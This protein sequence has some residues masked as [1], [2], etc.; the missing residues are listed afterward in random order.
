METYNGHVRTP[1]DAIILFEACRIGL[2][3]R[4]QRRLSEKERQAVKSGSVFVWDEREAGMRRWTDGKSWSASRVSGSFLTY[5]EMEGKRGGG[6][7]TQASRAGK[8]PDSNRGS[9]EDPGEGGE[10]GPDGYRYKP[11]GLMKQSFSI[12]TST[13]QHLHLISYYARSHPTAPGLNQPSTDPALR[14]I[15]PQ[16][17]LYPE[18]SVND[19]QNL[20][21]VTRGPM[22]RPGFSI[23]PHSLPYARPG[24]AHAQP[25]ATA[26]YN[27]HPPPITSAPH[28]AVMPYPAYLPPLGA[29][30][31]HSSI[32]YGHHPHHPQLPAPYERSVH[33]ADSTLPP[34]MQQH[35]PNAASGQ[36]VPFYT[37]ARSPRSHPPII[38]GAPRMGSPGHPHGSPHSHAQANGT[39][40]KHAP[41]PAP[42]KNI[43]LHDNGSQDN[44][45]NAVSSSSA[46]KVPSI[47]ALMNGPLPPSTLAPA[48][49]LSSILD[50]SQP[51]AR[52]NGTGTRS[53]KPYVSSGNGPKDI[54]SEKIG[55][56]ED[57]RALRQ[58]DKV[59]TA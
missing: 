10:E 8:T 43:P 55:F 19:Q 18:S 12:T 53:P 33:P 51:Q 46:T 16:K 11:D 24:A 35:L 28:V 32:P 1:A 2:L 47:N 42:L 27:W 14:H 59:F 6:H 22:S 44:N 13:G 9:D 25:Y 56:G 15:R 48:G 31:G 38:I 7:G 3:P 58:L 23:S 37:P 57:M 21:V 29:S 54:P 26:P 45:N 36:V 40:P 20:P 41:S 49:T 30:D 4:V 52:A 39:S 50:G 17:G 34:P 5:R